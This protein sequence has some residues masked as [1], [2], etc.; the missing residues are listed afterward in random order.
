MQPAE[1]GPPIDIDVRPQPRPATPESPPVFSFSPMSYA[2]GGSSYDTDVTSIGGSWDPKGKG[3]DRSNVVD[4]DDDDE[5]RPSTDKGKGRAVDIPHTLS[6]Q[7]SFEFDFELDGQSTSHIPLPLFAFGSRDDPAMELYAGPSSRNGH[8]AGISDPDS[9]FV[10]PHPISEPPSVPSTRPPSA[11]DYHDCNSASPSEASHDASRPARPPL[12]QRSFSSLSMRSIRSSSSKSLASIKSSLTPSKIK[13]KVKAISAPTAKKLKGGISRILSRKGSSLS[14]SSAAEEDVVTSN[15][16]LPAEENRRTSMAHSTISD[17]TVTPWTLEKDKDKDAKSS[18]IVPIDE[19][20]ESAPMHTI[21]TIKQRSKSDPAV[22]STISKELEI[23]HH[24]SLEAPAPVSLSPTPRLINNYFNGALPHEVQLS[25]LK[26][27]IEIHEEELIRAE[28]EPDFLINGRTWSVRN[29]GYMRWVGRMKGLRELVKLSRVS[30]AWST[31]CLDGQLWSRL[32]IPS[33]PTPSRIPPSALLKI[34][35]TAGAFVR[36]LDLR[37]WPHLD[38]PTLRVITKHLSSDSNSNTSPTSSASSRS[39]S[40][41]S[42]SSHS[43]SIIPTPYPR[44]TNLTQITLRSCTSVT[45]TSLH[46][47]LQRSPKLRKLDLRALNAVTNPTCRIIAQY[48]ASELEELDLGMC[49]K[50]DAGG[51]REIF[52]RDGGSKLKVL[53]LAGLKGV[54]EEFMRVLGRDVPNLEVLDLSGVEDLTDDAVE[55]FTEWDDTWDAPTQP[56]ST[57]E[58]IELTARQMGYDPTTHDG[59]FYKR[60]TSLRHVNLSDCVLLTDLACTSLAY[61]VPRLEYLELAGIGSGLGESGLVRLLGTTG[62]IRGVDL[63]DAV[64]VG[65]EVL[66]VLTPTRETARNNNNNEPQ[67]GDALERLTLSHASHI[68]N[69]SLLSLIRA[70]QN[71]TTLEADNT[72]ISASTIKEFIRLSRERRIRNACVVAVDCRSVTEGVVKDVFK[73]GGVRGRMGFRGWEAGLVS[74]SGGEFVDGREDLGEVDECD[75][76]RVVL[77]SF[78]SWQNVDV[79]KGLREKKRRVLGGRRN[80]DPG[81]VSGIFSWDNS[82]RNNNNN[83][84]GEGGSG[85]SRRWLSQWRGGAGGGIGTPGS[86]MP[87]PQALGEDEEDRSCVVM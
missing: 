35:T 85:G 23:Q 9:Q 68:S 69:A 58:K 77:K 60:I 25:I 54:N 67:P 4:D 52:E 24:T 56:L 36:T 80:T 74:A 59:P 73:E 30:K 62:R 50:V 27:L 22:L 84:N 83:N 26:A 14:G 78:W 11:L 46:Y 5:F 8:V 32:D 42:S 81:V 3:V 21:S 44:Q 17:I 6:H 29:A 12:H 38:P 1:G 61:C 57:R 70:C 20:I 41:S 45:S 43:E 75:E 55:A 10:L 72:R 33:S 64:E 19:G 48:C 82:G 7:P 39:H 15:P 66:G 47:L 16:N 31:L 49:R 53:R 34:A 13:G 65:D 86:F 51:V 71:L 28:N 76:R 18:S 63:E 2:Y 37:G 79:L 87:R 40:F